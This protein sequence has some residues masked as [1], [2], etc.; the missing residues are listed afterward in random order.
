MD[1][2]NNIKND[3]NFYGFCVMFTTWLHQTYG[4]IDRFPD[5]L[6]PQ[7]ILRFVNYTNDIV[8]LWSQGNVQQSQ[9]QQSR[10][11]A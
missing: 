11:S 7:V 5:R 6:D 8:D 2:T 3:T 10:R 1:R 4:S 9:L